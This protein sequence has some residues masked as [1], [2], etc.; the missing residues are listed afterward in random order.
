MKKEM[1]N[2]KKFVSNVASKSTIEQN[3]KKLITESQKDKSTAEINQY[4]EPCQYKERIKINIHPRIISF[5]IFVFPLVVAF[6]TLILYL[7]QDRWS[8]YLPT[9][10]ETG[11][12]YPNNDFFAISMGIGSFSTGFGLFV[13][14]VYIHQCVT[15]S[16]FIIIALYILASISSIGIVGLGF[17]SINEDHKHH[18][19]FASSGFFSILLFEFVELIS[20]KSVSLKIKK[21]RIIAL[22]IAVFGLILFGGIDFILSDRRIITINAFGEYIMLYFMMYIIYTY[23]YELNFV[24]I[25]IVIL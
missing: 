20:Q 6:I 24:N 9:I 12:E 10:S 23:Y 21:T 18:F 1:N 22:T 16:K 19:M 4:K 15:N 5:L 17:F 25:E 2:K 7:M 14:A 3:N 13:R 8:G 11:T